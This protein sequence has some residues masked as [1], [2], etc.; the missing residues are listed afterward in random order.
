[1]P[2]TRVI[3]LVVVLG[4]GLSPSAAVAQHTHGA[5]PPPA[6]EDR[7]DVV[8]FV[9]QARAATE[10]FNDQGAAVAAGY[11]LVGP[12]MPNMGE[13][14]VHLRRAMQRT[15]DPARP[16]VLTYVPVGGEALLTG[17]AYA[18]PMTS[19]EEAPD[20]PFE[21]A[22]HYHTGSLADEGFGLSSH[23]SGGHNAM[24][25]GA[26]DH[27][28]GHDGETQGASGKSGPRL[29]MI[30]AW[31]YTPNPDGL[32]APDNWALSF[33]RLGLSPPEAPS[34]DA[35]RA[36]FLAAGGVAYYHEAIRH[37][38]E[39]SSEQDDAVVA[40][41]QRHRAASLALLP[42]MHQQGAASPEA[43]RALSAIWERVWD[44]LQAA[45]PADH[46]AALAPMIE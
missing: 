12:D 32:F 34:P 3:A 40:F 23:E 5:A 35:S 36:L 17:V 22:W 20:F 1:M 19:G 14:W 43:L 26:M 38:V 25:H 45:L 10:R 24:N 11:R 18:M 2:M 42:A 33:V 15:L 7:P 29:A 30:H 8:A 28:G 9:E 21:G 44:D 13:H 41:L 39:L 37:A 27:R 6:L 46:V 16:A 4:V 31:I